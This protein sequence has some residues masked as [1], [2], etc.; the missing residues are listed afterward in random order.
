MTIN[1]VWMPGIIEKTLEKVFQKDLLKTCRFKKSPYGDNYL[2][3]VFCNN[4]PVRETFNYRMT[5]FRS[6]DE[7]NWRPTFPPHAY[8]ASTDVRGFD[9]NFRNT[10]GWPG[11]GACADNYG[12]VQ[13]EGC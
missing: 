10:A 1:P 3:G 5:E 7:N 6:I 11:V 12:G 13:P 8:N 4:A 2:D 9:V